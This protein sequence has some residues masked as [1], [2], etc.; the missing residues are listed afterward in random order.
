MGALEECITSTKY[1]LCRHAADV[2]W[3]AGIPREGSMET[4]SRMVEAFVN[5]RVETG[6]NE[7]PRQGGL[8]AIL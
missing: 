4:F 3:Y 7:G 6:K 1:L 8:C 2:F 5:L